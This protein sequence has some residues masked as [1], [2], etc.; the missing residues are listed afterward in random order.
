MNSVFR[1]L[2]PILLAVIATSQYVA[3]QKSSLSAWKGG[4]F[5]LFSTNDKPSSRILLIYL[6]VN[7]EWCLVRCPSRLKLEF[8]KIR[9]SPE[10]WRIQEFTNL[11]A[12]K[13]WLDYGIISPSLNSKDTET[14]P[15]ANIERSLALGPAYSNASNPLGQPKNSIRFIAPLEEKYARLAPPKSVL[16]QEVI[17]QVWKLKFA[18]EEPRISPWLFREQKAT[19]VR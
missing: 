15:N 19:V 6:F 9:S 8:E 2:A 11:L 14:E 1:Y 5:G 17:V 18:R 13:S 12:Q 7:G 4:G 10:I 16:V 3:V